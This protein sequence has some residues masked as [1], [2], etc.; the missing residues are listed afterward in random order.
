MNYD[1]STAL[2]IYTIIKAVSEDLR[3]EMDDSTYFFD[4]DYKIL[5]PVI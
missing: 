2:P 4:L 1:C 3:F 5:C